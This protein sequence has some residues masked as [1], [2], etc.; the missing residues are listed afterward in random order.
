[1]SRAIP[2]PTACNASTNCTSQTVNIPGSPGPAGIPGPAGQNGINAF[3]RT[4]ANF[5]MP[6]EGESVTVT[7]LNSTWAAIGQVVFIEGAGYLEVAGI[8]NSTSLTLINLEET[9]TSK[10]TDN[11]APTTVIASNAGVSPG[12]VQGPPPNLI[13]LNETDGLYYRIRMNNE[14]G[15][16]ALFFTTPP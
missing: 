9:A 8:P 12:G 5:T 2:S 16:P 13:I 15:G 4:T 10:Y 11:A 1:M 14:S 7:V 6:A 3:T